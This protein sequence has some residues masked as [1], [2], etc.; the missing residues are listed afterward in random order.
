MQL[1][2][3]RTGCRDNAMSN[4]KKRHLEFIFEI[5]PKKYTVVIPDSKTGE[6]CKV[7]SKELAES[8]D[9]Y[10]G[11]R[12][13]DEYMFYPDITGIERGLKIRNIINN[14]IKNSIIIPKSRFYC[15]SVHMFRTTKAMKRYRDLME[16][17]KNEA[18]KE[19]G[20]VA[21]SNSTKYYLNLD[22]N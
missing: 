17:A 12:A 3:I 19:I 6:Y 4:L 9:N 5:D 16:N 8:L 18:G 10:A 13:E 22:L 7:I 15:V 20:H 1:F 2:L 11:K 21:N 14:R